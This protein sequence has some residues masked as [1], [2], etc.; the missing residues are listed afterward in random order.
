MGQQHKIPAII[1][2]LDGTLCNASHRLHY[3]KGETKEWDKFFAAA[4]LDKCNLWCHQLIHRMA[5]A[6][7]ILFV[8]G[9][10]E[11]D[12]AH[13]MEWIR[14]HL[15]ITDLDPQGLDYNLH[16]RPKG[17]PRK[18]YTVKQEIYLEKIAKKYDVLFC[19][20][21]RGSVVKMWRQL[22]LVCLQ[23]DDWEERTDNNVHQEVAHHFAK[24][25]EAATK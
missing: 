8:T 1:V 4:S 16:M 9:R 11:D 21:D 17:D 22:G 2:D 18:D 14:K 6:F 7:E 10:S 19:V 3:L 25:Q 20:E 15:W 24:A 5:G 23:C 12:R 13:T